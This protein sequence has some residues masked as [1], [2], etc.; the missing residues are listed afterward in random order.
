MYQVKR[1]FRLSAFVITVLLRM[2]QSLYGQ[3]VEEDD[4][5]T[6]KATAESTKT[7]MPDA[8]EV[9]DVIVKQTNKFRDAEGLRKLEHDAELHATAQYF[10]DYM[11]RTDR[12]GH[13]AD[14][15][16][17]SERAE[18]YGYMYCLI[19]ENIAYQY[20]SAGFSVDELAT[21]FVKGW[22][23]SPP[24]RKNMLDA[25]VLETGVAVAQSD[26][27]GYWYAVQ[28]FGR[29]KSAAIE[30]TIT[31]RSD[32]RVEYTIR[33]RSFLLP[34]SYTRT[35]MR[36]RE[37]QVNFEFPAGRTPTIHPTSGDSYAIVSE[38]GQLNIQHQRQQ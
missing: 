27:S 37:P 16:R 23:T 26:S 33:D 2:S 20:S 11:A 3:V 31:N 12:Y 4:V 5:E 14:G 38:S 7:D 17:P 1:L 8:E 35:H 22:K 21:G 29:P 28:M 24:H 9:A 19:A 25:D 18:T 34:P 32:S 36:C 30:F 6:L 13:R 10:A 15:N